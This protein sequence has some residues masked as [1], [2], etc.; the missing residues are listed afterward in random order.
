MREIILGKGK[1]R[2]SRTPKVD[3]RLNFTRLLVNRGSISVI[4][5]WK[6]FL[7]LLRNLLII[8]CEVRLV[9]FA[10]GKTASVIKARYFSI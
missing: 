5:M 3:V 4:V 10:L 9:S 1:S 7:H 8:G 2:F 6:H